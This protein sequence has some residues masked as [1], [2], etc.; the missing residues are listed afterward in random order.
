MDLNFNIPCVVLL[1]LLLTSERKDK[2]SSVHV[3]GNRVQDLGYEYWKQERKCEERD[4]LLCTGGGC[5]LR[6]FL[7]FQI[8]SASR[9]GELFQLQADNFARHSSRGSLRT[10]AR[11]EQGWRIVVWLM[12]EGRAPAKWQHFGYISY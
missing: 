12:K 11:E 1:T 3:C 10:S 2:K 5:R 7:T 8:N 9:H 4:G 6:V